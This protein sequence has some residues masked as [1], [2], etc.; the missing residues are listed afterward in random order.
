[1][2]AIRLSIFAIIGIAIPLIACN[3]RDNPRSQGGT[4]ITIAGNLPLTGPIASFSGQYPNGFTMG[5]D[6]ACAALGVPRD[7]F[8]VDFQDNAGKTTNAV[9]VMRQQLL[10]K[11]A[12]YVSGTSAMSDAIVGEV[13]KTDAIHF[14]VSFDAFMTHGNPKVFRVLPNFKIEAPIFADF[15]KSRGAKRVFFFTPNLKAYLEQSD[16]LVL[17]ALKDARIVYQRE[18][19]EFEAKEFR[20]VA[21]KAA[22]FKPDVIIVSGYAFHVYPIIRALRELGLVDKAAVMSTLDFIDLLHGD[23][24]RDDLKNIYF[25]SPE[26]EIPGRVKS[27][28]EWVE[29]FRTR[30]GTNPSYVDA[31]AYDTGR[32]VVAA[33]KNAGKVDATSFKNVSP[34][35]GIVGAIALDDDRDLSSTLVTGYF[36]NDGLVVERR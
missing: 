13:S 1:M 7:T 19:F 29:R 20:T 21:E 31:Y 8:E 28:P 23:A 24:A 35:M 15:I 17:P 14:L 18:L 34:F 32:M 4:K 26:C 25:T 12:V 6:E 9:A 10:S 3:Q 16:K 36:G 30:F 22:R 33:F 11:P 2:R 27:Y 5:L